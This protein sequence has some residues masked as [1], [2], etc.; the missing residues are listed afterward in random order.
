[1]RRMIAVALALTLTALSPTAWAQSTPPASADAWPATRAGQLARGWVTAFST[2]EVAMR[3][4][5][6]KNM[7][8]Q[9]LHERNT[10]VRVEKYRTL[11]EQYA[12]LQLASVVKSTPGE[13]TAKLIDADAK[14]H[15][16]VF[17]VQT[18]APFKLVSVSMREKAS[19]IHGMFGG[20][21]H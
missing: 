13:L 16:F 6:D 15:E 5:L 11:R 20:F 18:T 10:R 3:E 1:M 12:R 17:V 2:G 19:G 4:F 8:S 14:S 7:A 21:H 9:A